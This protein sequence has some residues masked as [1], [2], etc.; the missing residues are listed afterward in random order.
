MRYEFTAL[1]RDGGKRD[2]SVRA[3][4][5][6]GAFSK[7]MDELWRGNLSPGDMQGVT[8]EFESGRRRIPRS[9]TTKSKVLNYVVQSGGTTIKKAA[10]DLELSRQ[11]TSVY[12]S[13]LAREGKIRR[14]KRAMYSPP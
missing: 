4:P 3:A 5:F 10:D 11:E 8:W 2:V 14:I 1:L 13:K 6:R 7:L 12:L 9:G